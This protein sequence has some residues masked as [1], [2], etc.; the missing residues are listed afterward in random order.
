[1]GGK[2]E[3]WIARGVQVG[4]VN[5]GGRDVFLLDPTLILIAVPVARSLHGWSGRAEGA[6]DSAEALVAEGRPLV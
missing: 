5:G 3:A 2:V 1:M 4:H 6:E